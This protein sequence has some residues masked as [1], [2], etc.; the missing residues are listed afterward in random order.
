VGDDISNESWN[1]KIGH[2]SHSFLAWMAWYG[3]TKFLQ[4]LILR[5]P[6]VV[7]PTLIGEIEQDY[8]Y[9][10]LKYRQ[11]AKQWRDETAWGRLFQRYLAQGYLEKYENN[12]SPAKA[13]ST[14]GG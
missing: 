9:W 7:V 8:L 14:V 3:P 1:F 10:P 11:I 13:V 12:L 4:K 6:L 2:N 5:T